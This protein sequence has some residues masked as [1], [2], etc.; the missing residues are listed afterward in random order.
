MS[1]RRGFLKALCLSAVA[2]ELLRQTCVAL[3]VPSIA[4]PVLP[5]NSGILWYIENYGVQ[6]TYKPITLT[7]IQEVFRK[8]FEDYKPVGDSPELIWCSPDIQKQI[9]DEI[10]FSTE[11]RFALIGTD[12]HR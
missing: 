3:S 11:T 1:S 2:P 4:P 9:D 8:M 5:I 10:R 12:V 6:H 7:S